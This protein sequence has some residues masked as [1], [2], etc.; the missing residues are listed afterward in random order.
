MKKKTSKIQRIDLVIKYANIH[1]YIQQFALNII[2]LMM[3]II[4]IHFCKR[5]YLSMFANLYGF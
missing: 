3:N 4:F 5:V 1:R 2:N